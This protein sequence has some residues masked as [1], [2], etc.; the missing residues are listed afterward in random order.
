M[1]K[2]KSLMRKAYLAVIFPLILV[3]L[4]S[5][6][7]CSPRDEDDNTQEPAKP[8][9]Y[10]LSINIYGQGV[11]RPAPGTNEYSEGEEISITVTPAA[12]WKFDRWEGDAS[13]NSTTITVTLD[14][15]RSVTACFKQTPVIF[16]LGITIDGEGTTKPAPGSYEYEMGTE[17][18]VTA[19][20]VPGWEFAHWQGDA[21]GNS[22]TTTVIMDK[23][24]DIIAYFEPAAYTLRIEIDG[25]GTTNPVSGTYEYD[26]D[27]VVT[28]TA[29]PAAGW[30]FEGW[31]GD[32][33]GSSLSIT[34]TMNSDKT[35]TAC[36][37][38]AGGVQIT[39]IFYDGL[40]P[41]VE[42]DEYVEITNLGDTAQDISGW[43]LID[44]SDGQ[45]S[46]TFPQ[47]VL[48]PGETIRVYTNEIHAEWGGFSFN[49]GRA[50]WDNS[51]PDTAILYDSSGNEVSRKSY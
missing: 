18:E 41:S 31:E 46:F 28:I 2:K 21:A 39:Y 42:S 22:M 34:T 48:E 49:Y 11:T 23:D 15:D 32:A 14:S 12:G 20:S 45:P 17:V 43:T 37:R 44:G 10:S 24:K 16:T 13:G 26:K 9:V 40:V 50:I 3:I 1:E 35:V 38:R 47:Y 29:F 8:A 4:S 27:T 5:C 51:S 33:S 6:I 7:S 25:E 36:F 19:S 30:V